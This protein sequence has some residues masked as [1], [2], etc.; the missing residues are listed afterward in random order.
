MEKVTLSEQLDA[1]SS[2]AEYDY[3]AIDQYIPG[4]AKFQDGIGGGS[5]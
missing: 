1:T 4:S 2:I 3:A 5:N